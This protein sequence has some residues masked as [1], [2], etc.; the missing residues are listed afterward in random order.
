[1]RI[2]C[3]N[4]REQEATYAG[5]GDLFQRVRE[6]AINLYDWMLEDKRHHVSLKHLQNFFGSDTDS[7][8]ESMLNR[9]ALRKILKGELKKEVI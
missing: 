1:M 5:Y 9:I 8:E 2:F 4:I 7:V 3:Q 6:K